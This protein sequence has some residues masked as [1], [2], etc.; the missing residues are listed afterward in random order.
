MKLLN[1]TPVPD[2]ILERLLTKAGR[3]VGARTS[4]VV[5]QVNRGNSSSSGC[6]GTAYCCS[7]VKWRTGNKRRK[8]AYKDEPHP[9]GGVRRKCIVL[10]APRWI[11]TDG[12]AFKISLPIAKTSPRY[13]GLVTAEN[14][15]YVARHE[16]GHIRDYQNGGKWRLP[17]SRPKPGKTRRAAHDDRPEEIRADR[18]VRHSDEA[19]KGRNWAYE[20][21]MDLALF[22][23]GLKDV[24][25]LD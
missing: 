25:K 15:M 17:W 6:R 5:V 19:R 21:V 8:Y 2:E 16:W 4:G 11:S 18:Y 23:E 20:E 10:N 7:S 14:F 9:E 24:K 3:S 22:L 12:G 1:N 13:D